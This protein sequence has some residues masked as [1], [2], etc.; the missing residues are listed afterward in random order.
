MLNIVKSELYK[1]RKLRVTYTTL[2]WLFLIA[3]FIIG[4]L[5]YGGIKGGEIGEATAKMGGI[6]A[7]ANIYN[8]EFYLIFVTLFMGGVVANE[9]TNSTIRQ[10]VSRGLSRTKILLGQYLA[11]SLVMYIISL[12]P[13]ICCM[14]TGIIRGG[15]GD[16]SIP[17]LILTLAAP[18]AVSLGYGAICVFMA[19]L[20]RNG[21]MAIGIT[22]LIIFVGEIAVTILGFLTKMDVF[23]KY[24]L[25]NILVKSFAY[26]GALGTQAKFIVIWL[27]IGVVMTGV[28]LLLFNKRDVA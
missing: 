20:L 3:A 6:G 5:V 4:M 17:Q 7:F 27:G 18:L 11:L 14:I 15:M 24:W 21:G 25:G 23:T 19:Q 28:N 10:V 16:V 12:I 9:Y 8:Q 2:I 26:D 13:G 22:V 1:A